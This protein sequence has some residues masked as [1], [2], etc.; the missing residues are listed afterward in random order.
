VW[1]REDKTGADS[2]ACAGFMLSNRTKT[3]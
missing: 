3:L 1:E 2:V